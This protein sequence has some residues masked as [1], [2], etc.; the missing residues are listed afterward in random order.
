M[1]LMSRSFTYPSYALLAILVFF[2][3]PAPAPALEV[4]DRV[5]GQVN[6]EVI[7]LSDIKNFASKHNL[8]PEDEDIQR[9]LL[10]QLI[11][12]AIINQEAAKRGI[13]VSDKDVNLAIESVKVR[14]G[15][16]DEDMNTL[17]KTQNM[18]PE[19]FKEQWRLQLLNQKLM[20]RVIG[21][22][23]PVTE[24]EIIKV[25]EER[26]GK[27]SPEETVRISHILIRPE[28]MSNEEARAMAEEVAKKA[29]DGDDFD[30]L[31]NAYSMDPASVKK[32]GDLG[33]FKKGEMVEVL[34]EAIGNADKGTVIGPV[35]STAGYHIIK[36]TDKS[37]TGEI[38]ID[39]AL[40]EEIRDEIYKRKV[41]KTL[42]EW[43]NKTKKTA[44][45]EKMI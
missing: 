21:G 37:V 20:N 15:L 38:N 2:S 12:L 13:T 45:I 7:T 35:L 29:K 36:V 26:H 18:T 25:Y 8:N 5:A 4:I 1:K 11:E 39:A 10:D 42:K 28:G 23:I 16:T 31:V 34:D 17:L 6:D 3:N 27:M 40:K 41:E 30:D 22:N 43:V 9:K 19:I 32:G 24:D 33:H 44:Y 14:H